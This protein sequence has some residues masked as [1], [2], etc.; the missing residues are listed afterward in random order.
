VNQ[1]RAAHDVAERAARESYGKLLAYLAK[2]CGG[3]DAA[4]EALA[5]AFAAALERWPSDGVPRVPEA[6]LLVTARN[7]FFDRAR[8]ERRAGLLHER[9]VAAARDAQHVFESATALDDARLD[10]MFACAH[11]SLSEAIRAPLILQAV[12]GLDAAR[13]ASAFLVAPATMGQRLVRAKRKIAATRIPF[14][15]PAPA[16]WPQRL[17]AVL[18]AIYAAYG[19]GWDAF[20]SADARTR[21]LAA[22]AIW[23]GR[24]LADVCP[25][26]PEVLG[27]LALMLHADARRAARRGADG[28]YV[29]LEDQEV[30]RWDAVAIEEAEA[31]LLRAASLHRVGRFQLEAAVQSVHAAR[32]FGYPTDWP[33]LATLYDELHRQTGSPVVALNR[34]VALGRADGA[35]CGLTALSELE[36]DARLQKYQPFWAARADL[37]A[38]AG[39]RAEARLAY[40]RAIGLS[41]DPAVRGY[42]A[43]RSR[44]LDCR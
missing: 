37:L 2:R 35:R 15:V 34:A 40:E 12:L 10:V 9:L 32:R 24:L 21:G 39:E 4:E 20:G 44:D 1:T 38:R 23:L 8:R 30:A 31:L 22:E 42:L 33:A 28:A 25:N 3:V 36:S 29:P 18:C 7:G 16:E 17:N 43:S 19:E 6:W 13:I 14:G 41:V 5:D 11:P 26:E 27:L